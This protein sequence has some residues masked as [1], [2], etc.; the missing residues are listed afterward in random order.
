M[1]RVIQVVAVL[2]AI[3]LP[4]VAAGVVL[5]VLA[6]FITSRLVKTAPCMRSSSCRGRVPIVGPWYCRRRAHAYCSLCMPELYR[7]EV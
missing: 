2:F 3:A 7:D 6:D 4:F 1:E 5:S